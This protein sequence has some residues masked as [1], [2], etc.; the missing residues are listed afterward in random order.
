L[1]RD[2]F[3]TTIEGAKMAMKLGL[4]T[5]IYLDYVTLEEAIRR[6][7]KI[8]FV[9]LDLWADSPHLD[10]FREDSHYRQRIREQVSDAGME[11]CALSVVGGAL[12]RRYNFS[13]SDEY[14]RQETLD[15]YKSCVDLA[16]EMGCPR[17]NMISGHMM[18]DTTREQAWQWNYE[19]MYAVCEYAGMNNVTMCIHTLTPS[20]SRVLVTL[21][22]AL[23]MHKQIDMPSCKIMIDTADQN[24][25]DTD[26][27]TAV[28]KSAKHLDYV[29]V[30]DN[31][32]SGIGLVHMIPGRGTVNWRVFISALRDV[33]Y[34]GYITAQVYSA[35]PIDPHSWVLETYD[36]LSK[37]LDTCEIAL[38]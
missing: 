4:C 22:D 5:M 24:I 15:Y 17:I 28:Q 25:T 27:T 6:T 20:E 30:S 33:A 9:G 1:L 14:V 3:L 11:I 16:A 35:Q 37:V 23:E 12:A 7:A 8:G 29:H 32:G 26:L 31:N 2:D 36:Y 21:D 13:Y 18:A 10:P 34:N 19:G 38:R